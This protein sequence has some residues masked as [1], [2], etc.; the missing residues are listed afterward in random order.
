MRTRAGKYGVLLLL[1][2]FA[3]GT[4]GMYPSRVEAQ[5]SILGGE[6][7]LI[8]GASSGP[9]E[10]DTGFFFGG[11]LD[12][13][14]FAK[15]PL[16]GQA[17]LGE[18]MVGWSRTRADR[19]SVS[20][21]VVVGAPAG[22]VTSTKFEVTTFQVSLDFKYKIDK[23]FAPLVPYVMFGPSFYVFLG[24]TYGA[25]LEGDHIGGVAPQPT[26]LQEVHFPSGQGNVEVGVNLGAGLDVYLAKR[27]ILGAEYRYHA[28]ARDEASH[29]TF[30]GKVGLRF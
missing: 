12:V 26:A 9:F 14:I 13:P 11:A 30:G 4:I 2:L 27:F 15:D 6:F 28:V 10:T 5:A 21:L 29:S 7:E 17:L 25:P 20:P 19:I 18:V 16:F 24:N 1:S 3:G 8:F 22:V 23:P